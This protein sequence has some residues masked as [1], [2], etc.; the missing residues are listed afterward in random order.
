MVTCEVLITLVTCVALAKAGLVV[1]TL[2]PS[3]RL[4]VRSSVRNTFGV[5]SLC[6][7][8][9]QKLSFLFIKTLHNDCSHIE[10]V[11]LPFCAHLIKI[12]SFFMV[13][14]L[15]IISIQNA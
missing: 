14:E 9:L 7:L 10:N 6:N 13:V 5:P 4:S 15:R 2:R 8:L 1:G 12:F 3:V 11:H